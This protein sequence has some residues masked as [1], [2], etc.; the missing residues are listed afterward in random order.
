MA[1]ESVRVSNNLTSTNPD[2]EVAVDAVGTKKYQRVKLDAGADG[3][4]LAVVAGQQTMANS[5]PV[6]LPSDQTLTINP[7]N[8]P[9]TT[10]WLTSIHDGTTK[11]T[12][13]DLASNDAL[14]VAVVDAT[15][16]QIT[17]FGTPDGATATHQLTQITSLQ[18]LDDVVATTGAAITTKGFAVSGTDGTNARILKTDTNG[19]LQIDVLTLPAVDT[20][21]PAAALL[22]DDTASPTAP[23]VGAFMMGRDPSGA[24]NWDMAVLSTLFDGDTGANT[25]WIAGA[26]LREASSGGSVATGVAANP[27]QVSLANTGSNATAVLV[28]TEF[29]AAAAMADSGSNTTAMPSC[30]N[31]N[32]IFNGTSWDR[33]RSVINAQNTTGTGIAAAGI[34][35]QLDD[36]ATGSVTENQF[37][38]VRISTRRA[39]L[40]EGVASGTAVTVDTELPAA[41]ALADNMINPTT[42]LIGSCNTLFDGLTWDRQIQVANA[43][44]SVGTGIAAAGLVAQLDDTSP[45]TITEN[46]FG[47]V[48]MTPRRAILTGAEVSDRSDTYTTTANGTTVDIGAGSSMKYFSIQVVQ[49]GT[50]TSW[51]VRLEGSLDGTNFSQIVAHTNADGSGTVKA[52]SVFPVRYFRSRCAGIVLGVGT[53]VIAYIHGTQ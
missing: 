13:R 40:I 33:Q 39:L 6:V 16:A 49:T 2:Y 31:R 43:L 1:D 52:S 30:G 21:L 26:M 36:T 4:A 10:P 48:R 45:T 25:Q 5:L 7:G 19:E 28:D 14:N 38:P 32:N 37:A 27:L 3:V 53:N 24:S 12:V 18:L 50:V 15:G 22:A 9:N 41:A 47:N 44:N 23:A 20:E 11:A 35:G 51:D 46:Q 8:T 29:P 17:T 42:A 34:L